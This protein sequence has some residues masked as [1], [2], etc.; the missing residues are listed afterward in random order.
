MDTY[1]ITDIDMFMDKPL[2]LYNDLYNDKI[3]DPAFNLY[4]FIDIEMGKEYQ[5]FCISD[6]HADIHRFWTFLY[7]QNFVTSE[8]AIIN[9][10]RG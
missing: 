7:L 9:K 1:K 2:E 10:F 8:L 4:K 3:K 5:L 6:I